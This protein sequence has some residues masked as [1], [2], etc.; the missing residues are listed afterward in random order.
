MEEV[1]ELDGTPLESGYDAVLLP[2]CWFYPN[3]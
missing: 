3:P 1:M 2:G